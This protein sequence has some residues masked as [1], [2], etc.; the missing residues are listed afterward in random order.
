MPVTRDKLYPTAV[1]NPQRDTSIPAWLGPL[2]LAGWVAA[3][4]LRAWQA[5]HAP[6][7]PLH[8]AFETRAEVVAWVW[9]LLRHELVF[10]TFAFILG[11][12]TA[13]GLKGA[14]PPG[15]PYRFVA[16]RLTEL[17]F[18]GLVLTLNLTLAWN[19]WPSPV[20]LILPLLVASLGIYFGV[21]ALGG[22]RSLAWS[23][24]PAAMLLAGVIGAAFWTVDMAV[25]ES[26]AP[27]NPLVL[28][29]EEKKAMAK[30]IRD[31][32]PPPGAPHRLE[33]SGHE[34]EGLINAALA[35]SGDRHK[36]KLEFMPGAASLELSIAG[37]VRWERRYLNL[38]MMGEVAI[39]SG[40]LNIH[41]RQ[42]RLGRVNAPPFMLRLLDE[43]L[44]AIVMDDPQLYRIASAIERLRVT[45]DVFSVMFEPGAIGQQVVP[46]LIQLAWQ[47][48]DVSYETGLYLRSMIQASRSLP[49]GDAGFAGLM[50]TAFN[51]A[52]QRS[53]TEDPRLENRAAVLALAL[54]LGH[55]GLEPLVGEVFDDT[56][57]ARARPLMG[58]VTLRGRQD[59]PRHFLVTAAMKLLA[60]EPMSDRVGLFK[61]QIDAR[62]G[63]SGFSFTDLMANMAGM[64]LA[65]GAIASDDSARRLQVT[66]AQ[67][68]LVDDFFPQAED[69]PEGIPA[70][71]L[72]SDYGGVGG[73]GYR[74]VMQEMQRRLDQLPPI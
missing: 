47:Q 24:V 11:L 49:R 73:P 28:N 14:V 67:G 1:C 66:L 32:R 31:S 42:M 68:F 57:R 12:L 29:V 65:I 71:R 40:H 51:Q 41:L 56:L 4:I 74:R 35:R 54:L 69:L 44:H 30:R 55:E 62:G 43:T 17:V 60:N 39:D 3:M 27:F 52:R 63:G 33:L 18:A 9:D 25:S 13:F 59:W 2:V 22:I 48:P 19:E 45:P 36:A 10:F 53:R 8:W 38:G 16:A 50:E 5:R 26:A 23:L 34:L 64:R 15:T 70:S 72:L 21:A 20:A 7:V 37:P 6:F 61:E 46:S 58:S